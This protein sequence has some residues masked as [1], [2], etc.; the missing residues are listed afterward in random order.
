MTGRNRTSGTRSSGPGSDNILDC[1][2]PSWATVILGLLV[3]LIGTDVHA[4]PSFGKSWYRFTVAE[5]FGSGSRPAVSVGTVTAS[6]TGQ[7][8]TYSLEGRDASR[9][10]I[11]PSTGA[12]T[13]KAGKAIS[14]EHKSL[15]IVWVK[16]TGNGSK[17]AS[18]SIS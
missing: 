12:L 13:T 5:N 17:S 11:D 2:S 15:Y 8:I 14:N 18:L 16:A 6:E 10:T 4:A 3:L 1:M 9:F 7:T